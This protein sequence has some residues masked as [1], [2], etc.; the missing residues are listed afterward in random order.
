MKLLFVTQV[1]DR[2]D[3]VL[4]AY[5]EWVRALAGSF[6]SIEV[7]CLREGEHELPA[8]VRVHSLGKE[9]GEAGKFIYAVRFLTLAWKLRPHYE[10]AFV[11]MNQEYVLLAGILWKILGKR[12][13]LW[14][15]H[16]A[17]SF[18]TDMAVLLSDKVFCTSHSSYIAKYRR[19]VF[20]PVGVDIT[21]F[22]PDSRI[23]R[24]PNSILFLARIAP[25]K[26]PDIFIDALG[27]LIGKGISFVASVYGSPKSGD[28]AYYESLKAKSE[29]LGLHGRV[30]FHGAIPNSKTPDVYRAH[31]IFVNCSPS[32]MF[33]KTLFEA[34]ACGALVLAVSDDFVRVAG[35]EYVYLPTAES[36][37]GRLE[38]LLLDSTFE[39]QRDRLQSVARENSLAALVAQISEVLTDKP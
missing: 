1:I 26:R 14:R 21:H 15:N 4:G 6:D 23:V 19:N 7:I 29:Q 11:H 30:H 39:V 28:E 36:L 20:M 10:A 37:A 34:A 33:D 8:N 22:T 12:I 24:A 27:I 2:N 18:L 16:Y 5:H 17:G 32:G 31:E 25:S 13:Y 38:Q 35:S 9:R 3:S